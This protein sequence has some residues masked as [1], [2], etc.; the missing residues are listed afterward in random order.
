MFALFLGQ[1][2]KV[3]MQKALKF[4]QE[5]REQGIAQ[6]LKLNK[7]IEM[8]RMTEEEKQKANIPSESLH[9]IVLGWLYKPNFKRMCMSGLRPERWRLE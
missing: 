9:E 6:V 2:D 3:D 1:A 5:Y 7:Q 4:R 8:R